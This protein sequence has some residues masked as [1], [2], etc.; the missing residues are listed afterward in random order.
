MVKA[1]KKKLRPAKDLKPTGLRAMALQEG[2]LKKTKELAKKLRADAAAQAKDKKKRPAKD[3]KKDDARSK[4]LKESKAGNIKAK[5]TASVSSAASK[6][7]VGTAARTAG[8]FAGPVGALV[9]MTSQLGDGQETKQS[10]PL[11]KGGRQPGYKY[12]GDGTMSN[13]DAEKQYRKMMNPTSGSNS[14]PRDK[15]KVLD[16]G[17]SRRGMKA[18]LQSY[19]YSKARETNNSKTVNPYKSVGTGN[20][21]T[22]NPYKAPVSMAGGGVNKPDVAKD[23]MKRQL[24]GRN[25][26]KKVTP[27]AQTSVSAKAPTFKG[28]WVGAAPTEMQKRGGAKIKRPNLLDLLR[29]KKR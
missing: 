6:S 29:K 9:A 26:D 1:P 17:E 19:R 25:P 16:R 24:Q 22:V 4:L 8:R 28:N 27:K 20:P 15:S 18:T 3:L 14:Q 10:G 23:K 11:M 13:K 7:L 2:K 5:P 12:P 21:K